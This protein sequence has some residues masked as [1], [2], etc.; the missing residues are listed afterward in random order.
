MLEYSTAINVVDGLSLRH[1]VVVVAI[2]ALLALSHTA[3][4]L[5][6]VVI[7]DGGH[8]GWWSQWCL[9]GWS[10]WCLMQVTMRVT[11]FV[12]ALKTTVV[13]LFVKFYNVS[14]NAKT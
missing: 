10:Q 4:L 1:I 8:D 13:I 14:H 11:M 5:L 12:K 2:G 6:P 9:Q 7:M 3:P